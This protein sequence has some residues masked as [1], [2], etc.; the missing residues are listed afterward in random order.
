MKIYRPEDRQEYVELW[1]KYKLSVLQ[2]WSWTEVKSQSSDVVRVRLGS[3]PVSVHIKTVPYVGWKFGY[4]P[5]GGPEGLFKDS[6]VEKLNKV[7]AEHSLSHMLID[8]YV[9]SPQLTELPAGINPSKEPW[10]QSQYTIVTD[11]L[12]SDEEMLDKMR[13][14][15]R[16]YIRKSERNGLILETDDTEKGL[17]RFTDVMKSQLTT[18]SYLP[19]S[20]NY[21]LKLWETFTGTDRLHIHIATDGQQ[22]VGA[23]MVIDGSDTVFQFYGGTTGEGRDKYAAYMLT[24]GAMLAAR[25]RGFKLYD[26]WGTAQYNGEDFDKSDEKYGISVFKD[27]FGGRK[28]TYAPQLAVVS[29]KT[30]Y[31]IYKVLIKLHRGTIKLRKIFK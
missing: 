21:F 20:N 29:S 25:E 28:I 12:H 14:K 31:N 8:P 4:I 19:Y 11:L 17:K 2:S 18:K 23:Y 24:W 5:H 1:S 10:V 22:D 6:I 30:R 15:H 13:K 27:G 26:Q 9:P 16:Q 7:M 3:Y